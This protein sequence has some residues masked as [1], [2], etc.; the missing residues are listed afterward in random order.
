[1]NP[2]KHARSLYFTPRTPW[3]RL[4][5]NRPGQSPNYLRAS[6]DA[7]L[8]PKQGVGK[9]MLNPLKKFAEWFGE[10]GLLG[11]GVEKHF[12]EGEPADKTLVAG[13]HL[14]GGEKPEE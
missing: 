14:G 13:V 12:G 10:H 9:G 7:P 1:M 4:P 2:S 11:A 5:Q 6:E 3:G 8:P